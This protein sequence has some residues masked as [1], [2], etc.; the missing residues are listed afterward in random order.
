MATFE[1]STQVCKLTYAAVRALGA[2]ETN[3]QVV[4]ANGAE[5]IKTEAQLHVPEAVKILDW[6]HL[7]R[8]VYTGI[9]ALHPGQSKAEPCL[10]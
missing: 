4:V 7:W 6:P 10:A 3:E 5:W 2:E 8:K 9:R 1:N